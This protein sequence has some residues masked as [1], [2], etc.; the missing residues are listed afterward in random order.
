[1]LAFGLYESPIYPCPD[2]GR[3]RGGH[4]LRRVVL[5]SDG[6]DPREDAA[7]PRQLARLQAHGNRHEHEDARRAAKPGFGGEEK[8]KAVEDTDSD[9]DLDYATDTD[10]EEMALLKTD[11]EEA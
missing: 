2:L 9:S 11:P 10:E 6:R 8:E 3:P 5:L 7:P 1:M 4:P